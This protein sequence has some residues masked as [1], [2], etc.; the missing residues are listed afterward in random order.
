MRKLS[1][2]K[3]EVREEREMGSGERGEVGLENRHEKRRRIIFAV[4]PGGRTAP[5]DNSCNVSDAL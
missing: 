5:A 3:G 1:K 4:N 2:G